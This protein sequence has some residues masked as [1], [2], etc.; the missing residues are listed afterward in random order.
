[1]TATLV[2][3]WSQTL[4][5]YL[6]ANRQ[7]DNFFPRLL[8]YKWIQTDLYCNAS[9]L[10]HPHIKLF[11]VFL[12]WPV[13]DV[14]SWVVFHVFSGLCF[15]LSDPLAFVGVISLSLYM[16]YVVDKLLLGCF[17]FWTVM[18][19]YW[20]PSTSCSHPLPHQPCSTRRQVGRPSCT[21]ISFPSR[22]KSWRCNR[23]PQ[24]TLTKWCANQ[25][26]FDFLWGEV[27]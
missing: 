10:R 5:S 1:M 22:L 15:V 11:D 14:L 19:G 2:A 25:P 3:N 27:M 12:A 16:E 4:T 8:V 18:P 20:Y 13:L 7:V 26:L 17:H 24:P 6:R 23:W 21:K 9:C